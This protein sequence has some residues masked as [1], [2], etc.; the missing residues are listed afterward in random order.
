MPITYRF[1]TNIVIVEMTGEYSMD[2]I[3]QIVLSSLADSNCP[4]HPV[5]MI[6]LSNSQSIYKR[7]SGEVRTI[8]LFMASLGM[9]FN[10]RFA[11]VV[12]RDVPYGLM[13]MSSIDSDDYG[14]EAEVFRSFTEARNWLLL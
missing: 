9:R 3:R 1:D 12:P 8:A 2:E 6:D 10:N 7:S 4:A 5:L 14:I 11:L 13:R